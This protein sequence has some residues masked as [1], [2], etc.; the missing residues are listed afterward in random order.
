MEK[1]IK[2]MSRSEM[3]MKL[4][5]DYVFWIYKEEEGGNTREISHKWHETRVDVFPNELLDSTSKKKV[6]K[7]PPSMS[8][9]ICSVVLCSQRWNLQSSHAT[10]IC[11]VLCSDTFLHLS[12]GLVKV[13]RIQEALD[14]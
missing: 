3:K 6:P 2:K 1:G 10:V 12:R 8:D 5:L 14:Q 11:Q 7:P 13:T 4:I 9:W